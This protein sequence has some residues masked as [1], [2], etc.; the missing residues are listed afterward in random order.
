MKIGCKYLSLIYLI[1]T[2]IMTSVF[3]SENEISKNR[4]NLKVSSVSLSNQ[5]FKNKVNVNLANNHYLNEKLQKLKKLKDLLLKL[6]ETEEKK[7]YEIKKISKDE[8]KDKFINKKINQ[9]INITKSSYGNFT[10]NS[11]M[12]KLNNNTYSTI[13]HIS[14]K[15]NQELDKLSKLSNVSIL[16]KNL[17]NENG[18]IPTTFISNGFRSLLNKQNLM[19]F[20]FSQKYQ[21]EEK[22]SKINIGNDTKELKKDLSNQ[23]EN[24]INSNINVFTFIST[25]SFSSLSLSQ[26][27]GDSK[28]KPCEFQV[29]SK[30]NFVFFTK[31]NDELNVVGSFY[32][33]EINLI[34]CPSFNK[35]KLKINSNLLDELTEEELQI[36]HNFYC[37]KL[38]DLDGTVSFLKTNN[39]KRLINTACSINKFLPKNKIKLCLKNK[40][41]FNQI[42]NKNTENVNNENQSEKENSDQNIENVIIIPETSD[43]CNYNWDYNQLGN[44]WYCICKN[45]KLQS[46]INLTKAKKSNDIRLKPILKYKTINKDNLLVKYHNGI[47]KIV[48]NDDLQDKSNKDLFGF[49]LDED[50]QIYYT[51]E[52][53][54]H[55]PSEHQINGVNFDMEMQ[56]IHSF[57]NKK[58]IF[59]FLFKKTPGIFNKFFEAID[60]SNLP[61]KKYNK[62]QL[63]N[64]VNIFDVIPKEFSYY[65][66]NGSLTFPPCTENV[67]YYVS[68]NA[69]PLSYTIIKMFEEALIEPNYKNFKGSFSETFNESSNNRIIQNLNDREINYNS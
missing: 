47:I 39:I 7:K 52:I 57:S 58:L 42:Q 30:D 36:K 50:S 29:Y 28:S 17:I 61:N 59:S 54:F 22:A 20:S 38:V 16:N 27:N 4:V 51:E 12:E 69:I 43:D 11:T 66:Y 14:T 13:P 53:L 48:I 40:D 21:D 26:C 5:N 49:I 18:K 25:P 3:N 63:F 67:K 35:D 9:N 31:V 15:I 32:L 41:A 2:F 8:V 23:I 19:K 55:T 65:S 6:K 24:I 33:K 1:F 45:G 37:I 60:F 34:E 10:L 62:K 44:D 56:I 64:D 46:P 68:D